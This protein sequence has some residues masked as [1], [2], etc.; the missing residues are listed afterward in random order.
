MVLHPNPLACP[1]I[2]LDRSFRSSHVSFF[3]RVG[4][5]M[6]LR[7]RRSAA[8]LA[9]L[10]TGGPFPVSSRIGIDRRRIVQNRR[11]GADD[12]GFQQKDEL[13]VADAYPIAVPQRGMTG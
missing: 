7:F 1:S 9:C 4:P 13:G 11:A 5:S 2:P 10:I 8:T 12:I 6:R 3:G